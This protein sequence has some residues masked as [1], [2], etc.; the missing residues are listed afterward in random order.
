MLKLIINELK[1]IGS[2]SGVLFAYRDGKLI[3][4]D[5]NEKFDIKKF[6]AMCASLLNGAIV[7]GKTIGDRNI[8]KIVVELNNQTIMIVGCDK[9]TFLMLFIE[10]YTKTVVILNEL[11]NYIQKIIEAY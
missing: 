7:L 1:Q 5:V 4:E 9:K 2:L 6:I 3:E 10:N 8:S 11:E